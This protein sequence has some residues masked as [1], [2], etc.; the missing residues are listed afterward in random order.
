MTHLFFDGTPSPSSW[1]PSRVLFL[2]ATGDVRLGPTGRTAAAGER[3]RAIDL[4]GGGK[5]PHWT[6]GA[7]SPRDAPLDDPP[8]TTGDDFLDAQQRD[9]LAR[10]QGIQSRLPS[11]QTQRAINEVNRA[12][13]AFI[14]SL[15]E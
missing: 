2:H 11:P 3:D 12:H 14:G 9:T 4:A 13:N 6:A 1:L 7:V 15:R 10:V 8:A 5:R